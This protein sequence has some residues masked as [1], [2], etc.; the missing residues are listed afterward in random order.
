V[1]PGS[2]RKADLTDMSSNP[3]AVERAENLAKAHG[4]KT[5]A[6]KVDGKWR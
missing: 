3:A 1:E 6:Y 4:V 5:S 2:S